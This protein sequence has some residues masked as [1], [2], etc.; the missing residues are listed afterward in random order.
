M[1][2]LIGGFLG[3]YGIITRASNFGSA[4]TTNMI[5]I[6]VGIFD[7]NIEATILRTL[8]LI[9]YVA[10][11]IFTIV[12]PKVSK[13]D[14]RYMSLVI[15]GI[16]MIGMAFIASEVHPIIALFPIF[17]MS[18]F[19]WNSFPKAA[20]YSCSTIFSTNNLRQTIIG[21]TEYIANKKQED[22][23]K[24]KFY[25]ATLIYYYLG[26]MYACIATRYMGIQASITGLL[27]VVVVWIMIVRSR[28]KV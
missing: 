2:I 18:A 23:D 17:F 3:G 25:G 15:S 28:N 19:Q 10:A 1:A 21:F 24:G 12:I 7:K 8:A 11:I 9:I 27:P 6:I 26:V 20:G 5:A 4:E 13:F 16:G 22:L 14:V